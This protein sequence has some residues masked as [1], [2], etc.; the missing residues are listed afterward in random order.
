MGKTT[1]LALILVLIFVIG[2]A[3]L[4]DGRDKGD[5]EVTALNVS[6][7]T[8]DDG[9]DLF[10]RFLKT[11]KKSQEEEAIPEN[12]EGE[13]VAVST[14]ESNSLFRHADSSGTTRKTNSSA[15][16]KPAK[17]VS[18]QSPK[19]D[20]IGRYHI[21]RTGDTATSI[22]RDYYGTVR[23]WRKI[24]AANPGLDSRKMRVGKKIAIPVLNVGVDPKSSNRTESRVTKTSPS[25]PKG[26]HVVRNGEK[27]WHI[28]RRYLGSGS[29]W[30]EIVEINGIAD[31]SAIRPGM[32]LKI[33][34]RGF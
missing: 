31:P 28:A 22:S 20:Q 24:I 15:S 13:E 32:R 21:I 34:S 11:Q 3:I 26:F 18:V 29:R 19:R 2:T 16:K 27:L 8:N 6:Q 30:R 1:R 5:L 33:P 9:E 14:G 17:N 4:M 23:Y 12:S 10:A 25:I 7:D